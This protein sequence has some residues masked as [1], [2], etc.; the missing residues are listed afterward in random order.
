MVLRQFLPVP[1]SLIL[2]FLEDLR[3]RCRI[4]QMLVCVVSAA[5]LAVLELSLMLLDYLASFKP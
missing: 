4:Y 2:G 5:L 3:D 1:D